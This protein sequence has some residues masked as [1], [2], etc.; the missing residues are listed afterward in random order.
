MLQRT[1]QVAPLIVIR[2]DNRR[3]GWRRGM[4][5]F[6]SYTL[7]YHSLRRTIPGGGRTTV[8]RRAL[9]LVD[10][11]DG[12][13]LGK[14]KVRFL[15]DLLPQN[16][17]LTTLYIELN[18]LRPVI[19]PQS[20]VPRTSPTPCSA[21]PLDLYSA[22]CSFQRPTGHSGLVGLCNLQSC[23]SNFMSLYFQKLP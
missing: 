6:G 23:V 21:Y 12:R 2:I 4:Q 5:S 18:I 17:S 3:R 16:T 9:D 13:W 20:H 15:F 8:M 19:Q 7:I 11:L 10:A 1:T 14:V 22:G